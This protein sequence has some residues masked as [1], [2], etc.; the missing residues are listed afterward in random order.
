MKMN[1]Q[2]QKHN[3]NNKPLDKGYY[4]NAESSLNVSNKSSDS[5]TKTK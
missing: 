1:K 5:E 2:E 3:R 4:G